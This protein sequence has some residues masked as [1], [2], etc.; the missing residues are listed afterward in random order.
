MISAIIVLGILAFVQGI[1]IVLLWLN[2]IEL[3][4]EDLRLNYKLNDVSESIAIVETKL[5]NKIDPNVGNSQ[6][7]LLTRQ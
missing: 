6:G 1:A 4:T 5:D 7:R 2:V 3:E